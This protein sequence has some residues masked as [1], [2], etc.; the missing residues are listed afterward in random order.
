MD[1]K[2]F[3]CEGECAGS[4]RALAC[5]DRRPRRSVL[6]S[7]ASDRNGSVWLCGRRGRRPLPARRGRSPKIKNSAK[8]P[9]GACAPGA[10][11]E[12]TPPRPSSSLPSNEFTGARFPRVRRIRFQT[13]SSSCLWKARRLRL[14]AQ[15]TSPTRW[16]A[17]LMAESRLFLATTASQ[18]NT[19]PRRAWPPMPP[20]FASWNL[21]LKRVER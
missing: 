11:G 13:Q 7:S 3:A 19:K 20:G 10:P 21:S 14:K 2:N 8:M 9:P 18:S 4:I 16:E 5:A 15:M 12:L 1:A 17:N 6:V